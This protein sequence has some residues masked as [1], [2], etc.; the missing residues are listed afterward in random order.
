MPEFWFFFCIKVSF[1]IVN[2]PVKLYHRSFFFEIPPLHRTRSAKTRC[3]QCEQTR[4]RRQALLRANGLSL[5]QL[6]HFLALCKIKVQ[7]ATVE[8]GGSIDQCFGDQII[9]VH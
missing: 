9:N 7:R 2:M 6:R 3:K 1:C 8:P 5:E 4:Q